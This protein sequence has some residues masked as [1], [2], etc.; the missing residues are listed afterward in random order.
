MIT[1]T[2]ISLI[3][4][5]GV[6]LLILS[7]ID[8]VL[9]SSNLDTIEKRESQFNF[10][11]FTSITIICISGQAVIFYSIRKKN[12]SFSI[13]VTQYSRAFHILLYPLICVSIILFTYII[14]Q[15]GLIKQYVT[16]P[17]NDT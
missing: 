7:F 16:E 11:V 13:K 5:Y 15:T 2:K 4:M 1:V 10:Y 14:R 17:V 6:L 8:N 12:I 9:M 3:V